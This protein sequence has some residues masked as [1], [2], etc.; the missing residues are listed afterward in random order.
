M[1]AGDIITVQQQFI[2]TGVR[3]YKAGYDGVE[4]HE[5]HGYLLC[6]FLNKRVNH[7]TDIYGTQPAKLAIDI[8]QG[9]R[10]ATSDDFPVGIRLGAFEPA[11][12]DS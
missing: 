9:I 5:C 7:R 4:L 10:S 2:E 6:Q 12:E 3:A 8:M 11:L 1:T